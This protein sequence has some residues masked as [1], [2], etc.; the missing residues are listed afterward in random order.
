MPNSIIKRWKGT[1][2]SNE[3]QVMSV[4]QLFRAIQVL[5]RARV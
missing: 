5:E 4:E 2:F 3:H 1:Q